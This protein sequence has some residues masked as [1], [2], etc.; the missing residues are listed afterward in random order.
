MIPPYIHINISQLINREVNDYILY[1]W[2]NISQ[3]I[4]REVSD[5][6]IYGSIFRS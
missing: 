4:N 6:Y 3:L 1:I 2:I 5:S